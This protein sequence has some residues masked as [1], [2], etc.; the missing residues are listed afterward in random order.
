M[1]GPDVLLKHSK[2]T[3]FESAFSELW[4]NGNICLQHKKSL[5]QIS[6]LII[7]YYYFSTTMLKFFRICTF[8]YSKK[9]L[10]NRR[11]RFCDI[12]SRWTSNTFFEGAITTVGY[13]H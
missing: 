3:F 1:L 9:Q 8:S 2:P 6:A 11:Q 12:I 13:T 7:K 10:R 5:L 4:K